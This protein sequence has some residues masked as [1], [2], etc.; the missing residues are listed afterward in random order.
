MDKK[1]ILLILLILLLIGCS[2]IMGIKHEDVKTAG[3]TGLAD[4]WNKDHTQDGNHDAEQHQFLNQVIENRT[5]MPAGPVEGQIIYRTDENE[6]YTW[7]GT[8]WQAIYVDLNKCSLHRTTVQTLP[9]GAYTPIEWDAELYDLNNMHDNAVDPE[10]ITIKKTGYYLVE[11]QI[12]IIPNL[13]ASLEILITKNGTAWGDREVQTTEPNQQVLN[14]KKVLYLLKDDW[15]AVVVFHNATAPSGI[16]GWRM[17]DWV[18]VT[19]L[20]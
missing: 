17:T 3:E 2:I 13:P 10:R 12:Y 14:V 11:A 7:D 9:T 18:T 6:L 19:R 5:D 15:I 16:A 8:A 4:E 20:R 1:V